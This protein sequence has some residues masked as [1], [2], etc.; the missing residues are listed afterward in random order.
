M[1][2]CK[3]MFQVRLFMCL[4][5]FSAVPH[6]LMLSLFLLGV[7]SGE[8]VFLNV[9][10]TNLRASKDWVG[11]RW[12]DIET[13]VTII[14]AISAVISRDTKLSTI[15][16]IDKEAKSDDFPISSHEVLT[17]ANLNN[18]E[19][20]KLNLAYLAPRDGI[21][22]NMKLD[23]ACLAPQDEILENMDCANEELQLGDEEDKESNGNHLGK[24]HG[25]DFAECIHNNTDEDGRDDDNDHEHTNED[26][27]VKGASE[28]SGQKCEP[29]QMEVV[30][31]HV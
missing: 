27:I 28:T 22:E 7:I 6:F 30:A 29:Y 3:F 24:F 26:K 12:V 9:H 10:G 2:S 11:S 19:E 23:T 18:F 13:N 20:E 31:Q 1:E 25:K 15:S 17:N 14:S 21:L 16:N 8:N 5:V 4:C